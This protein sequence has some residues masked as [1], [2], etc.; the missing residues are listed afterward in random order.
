MITS[1]AE[2]LDLTGAESDRDSLAVWADHEES[3]RGDYDA[4]WGLRWIVA[5]G[6]RPEPIGVEWFWTDF[7]H[8]VLRVSY[9]RTCFRLL[10]VRLR[11]G[12][13]GIKTYD[14]PHAAY[15]DLAQAAVARR[16]YLRLLWAV[17]KEASVNNMYALASW[18]IERRDREHLGWMRL[19]DGRKHPGCIVGVNS[20]RYFWQPQ[21]D[22]R[23]RFPSGMPEEVF[24]KIGDRRFPSKFSALLAAARAWSEKPLTNV[25]II[26]RMQQELLARLNVPREII[27]GEPLRRTYRANHERT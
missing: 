13:G 24:A 20:R 25:E 27:E 1:F 5:K 14:T 21:A 26:N 22:R 12:S 19:L 18:L 2:Q 15:L 8:W 16:T 17:R 7:E 6:R 23:F 11:A 3:E 9:V 10:R 4:A